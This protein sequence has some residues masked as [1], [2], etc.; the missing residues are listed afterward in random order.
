MSLWGRL[1]G[2]RVDR[3]SELGLTELHRMCGYPG[4]EATARMLVERGANVNAKVTGTTKT[5]YTPLHFAAEANNAQIM[6]FL[7]SQGAEVNAK[8]TDR[9]GAT[10]LAAAVGARA[11]DAIR[12]LIAHGADV[13]AKLAAN[14][15]TVTE[16]SDRTANP[17]IISLV[18]GAEDSSVRSR[19]Q[20]GDQYIPLSTIHPERSTAVPIDEELRVANVNLHA[21]GARAV[22]PVTAVSEQETLRQIFDAY[23]EATNLSGEN[24]SRLPAVQIALQHADKIAAR[25]ESWAKP[26]AGTGETGT[27]E[28]SARS[29]EAE[30]E[31]ANLHLKSLGVG[32]I[33]APA[34]GTERK[35][36]FPILKA[37]REVMNHTPITA[38]D[39]AR[40]RAVLPR[41]AG[42]V[43]ELTRRMASNE[44][45]KLV[46]GHCG[47][48]YHLGEDTI[49]L[50]TEELQEMASGSVGIPTFLFI[51]HPTT[52]LPRSALEREKTTILRLLAGRG[53]ECSKCNHRH[54]PDESIS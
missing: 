41:V 9:Y 13:H 18:Q 38:E 29:I 23:L 45:T 17:E 28:T 26:T 36:L 52:V 15:M 21:L 19:L 47:E 22:V 30:Y 2:T 16:M 1:F 11:T 48:V 27:G 40:S 32:P 4:N 24:L 35:R 31:V 33:S 43:E 7:I 34:S 10:P 37:Y 8:S 5:G 42:H 53:W 49:S 44:N 14:R 54:A 50:S 25:M 12:V 51:G 3:R 20:S 6:E 46:C 39:L